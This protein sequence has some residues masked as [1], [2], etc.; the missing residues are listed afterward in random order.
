M[1][2]DVCLLFSSTGEAPFLNTHIS[3]VSGPCEACRIT[4]DAR[5][6]THKLGFRVQDWLQLPRRY[7]GPATASVVNSHVMSRWF[8]SSLYSVVLHLR[9]IVL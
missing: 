8:V 1:G 2:T 3:E 6:L 9:R 5:L 7:F 4:H